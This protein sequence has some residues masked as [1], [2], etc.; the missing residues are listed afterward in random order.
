[1]RRDFTFIDD[2]VRG[3][4]ACLDGPPAD[5]G[6]VKAGGSKSPH[7]L[8]NIG[9]N[10]SRGADADGRPARAG[11]R[12]EGGRSTSSRCSRAT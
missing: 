5:D 9:N 11:D 12:Q 7:A 10:R 2:I 6:E 3:V 1:M 8:Y 4:L